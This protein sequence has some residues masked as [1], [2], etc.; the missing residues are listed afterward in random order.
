MRKFIAKVE[1]TAEDTESDSV[2]GGIV[3]A[4]EDAFPDRNFRF[5]LLPDEGI[6]DEDIARETEFGDWVNTM[7]HSGEMPMQPDLS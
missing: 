2:F 1:F 5:V 7:I 3:E 4:V 6:T